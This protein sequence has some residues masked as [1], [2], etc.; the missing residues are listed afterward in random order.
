VSGSKKVPVTYPNER[1]VRVKGTVNVLVNIDRRGNVTS[2]RAIC[3]HP[4]LAA[5]SVA[6]AR[7]WRFQHSDWMAEATKP[8]E[9]LLSS[10]F[11]RAIA[12]GAGA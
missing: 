9:S 4:L 6:A 10:S 3:G 5:S 8:Q 11:P 7:L 2:A 1:G 12:L